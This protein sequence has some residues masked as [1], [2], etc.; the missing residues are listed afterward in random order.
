MRKRFEQQLKVGQIPISR[1]EVNP[2]YRSAFPKL[3]LSLKKLYL[4]PEYN[5]RIFSILEGKMVKG[6]KNTGRPGMDLWVLFVM[7]QTRLCLNISYDELHRMAN[8]DKMFR[9]I[10]GIETEYGF[11]R[12]EFEYQNILDNV[13]LLDDE[14]VRKLNDVVVEMGHGV[15]K[16]KDTEAL[17]L[18]TDSFVVES[19]VHFPTDYNLLWDSGRKCMDIM[20]KFIKKYN[21]ITGWRKMGFWHRSLKSGMRTLGQVGKSGGKGKEERLLQAATDYLDTARLFLE[22]LKKEKPNLPLSDTRD[23]V[24]QLELEYYQ[25]MLEKHIDLVERRI[26]KGETIP[27]QEKLFSI[28]ETYTEWITKGK[29]NPGVELGKN[30]QVTTDQFHLIVDYKI[31][32]HEVDKSC[33]IPLSDRVLPRFKVG[34]WSFDKGFY[35]K[36]NKELLGLFI[37]HLVMPK[38]G[39][40]NQKEQEQE[41]ERAFKKTRNQHSA[42]ESNINELEHRGL[43]RCPDK[44][45]AHFKRYVGLGVCAYN[46]HRIGAELMR[47]AREELL[48]QAA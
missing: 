13:T 5:E 20:G 6:K 44:G 23:F 32:E 43:D 28:F 46:L 45:Y 40:L 34:S 18:K 2:K 15:F 26:I 47:Q 38:K 48:K 12:I 39:K 8:S 42:I 37:H 1:I 16:K 22:K 24:L 21:H 7:A 25:T 41:S 36:E 33:V 14:T 10:M 35:S 11:E 31:M 4:T 29:Q 3:V 19:D 9:E 27:H 30:F 17:R